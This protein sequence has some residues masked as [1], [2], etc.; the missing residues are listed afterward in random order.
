LTCGQPLYLAGGFGGVTADVA[1]ALELDDGRWLPSISSS[2]APDIRLLAGLEQLTQI[3]KK[4]GWK[5]S[6][7]GLTDG[8]NF[9][10]AASYRPSEIA[11]LVSL[12]LGRR[13]AASTTNEKT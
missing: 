8:E 6:D 9:L 11:A 10:L 4:T 13:F 12:G 5:R 2:P 7:N 1:K 3:A